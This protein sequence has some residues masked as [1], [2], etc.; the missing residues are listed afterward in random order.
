MK[1]TVEYKLPSLREAIPYINYY[2]NHNIVT[3]LALQEDGTYI[4]KALNVEVDVTIG[5]DENIVKK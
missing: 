2:S 1:K 5:N 4:L 3:C